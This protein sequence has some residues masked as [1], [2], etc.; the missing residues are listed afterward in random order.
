MDILS[1][2]VTSYEFR[3]ASCECLDASHYSKI[4][5]LTEAFLPYDLALDY[6]KL[7]LISSACSYLKPSFLRELAAVLLEKVCA[8]DKLESR[9]CV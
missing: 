4:S 3:L 1:G 5:L 6:I 7:L 9:D 8:R 2:E